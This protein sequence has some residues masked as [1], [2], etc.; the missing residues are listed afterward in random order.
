MDASELGKRLAKRL[1]ALRIPANQLYRGLGYEYQARRLALDELQR[2]LYFQPMFEARCRTV[3]EH[4]RLELCPDSKFPSVVNVDLKL[5][6]E[7]R[8]SARTS[9]SGARRAPERPVIE[10][11][12]HS[13]I[14]HRCTLRAG[15]GIQIGKHVLIATNALLSGDP[16][17]P[18]DALERRTDAAPPQSLGRIVLGDDVW[19]AYNV[20]VVGNV[21]IGEGAV[22]AANTVVT[23][24]VPPY[25]L[26][27]G[28]PGKVIRMLRPADTVA[29]GLSRAASAA[30]PAPT[31]RG[32]A[33]VNPPRGLGEHGSV[34]ALREGL[35]HV[36]EQLFLAPGESLDSDSIQRVDA[37]I[38]AG[39][40]EY[41]R[42][43]QPARG[44][45]G[46][47]TSENS[48]RP[49]THGPLGRR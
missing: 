15:T 30:M 16:G 36:Y 6:R 31:A 35:R 26:V 19:L 8:M 3:G 32:R 47:A 40:E 23:R 10:I 43:E 13:Y 2:I 29:G 42:L 38:A 18:L 27:A 25:A 5:G 4:F 45:S 9:F 14:G 39:L 20:T 11:G 49:D 41:R 46:T 34:D 37:A 22:I 44:S 17:H 28:N 21:T 24:D 48:P 12:D 33:P 7:V 1:F